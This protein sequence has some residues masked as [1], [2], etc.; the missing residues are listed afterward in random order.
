VLRSNTAACD[1]VDDEGTVVTF[2]INVNTVVAC[3]FVG[4]NNAASV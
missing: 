2:V 3:C 4:A 1:D